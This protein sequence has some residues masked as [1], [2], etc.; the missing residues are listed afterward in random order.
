MRHSSLGNNRMGTAT[1]TGSQV[2]SQMRSNTA[3]M[4]PKRKES[5]SSASIPM[6]EENTNEIS[7]HTLNLWD[8]S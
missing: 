7:A 4:R 5:A 3:Y 6:V 2:R 1:P 8:L